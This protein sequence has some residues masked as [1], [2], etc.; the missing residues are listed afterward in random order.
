MIV[1]VWAGILAV[2]EARFW[3]VMLFYIELYKQ[4]AVKDNPVP[5]NWAHVAA[6]VAI[7]IVLGNIILILPVDDSGSIVVKVKI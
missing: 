6:D 2:P 4:V 7:V 5:V 1:I 3:K